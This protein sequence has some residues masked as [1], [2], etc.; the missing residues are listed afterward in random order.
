MRKQSQINLG[1]APDLTLL[2]PRAKRW[3]HKDPVIADCPI[4]GR[5]H[6]ITLNEGDPLDFPLNHDSFPK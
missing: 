4:A 2:S 5:S 6:S 3:N 1:S